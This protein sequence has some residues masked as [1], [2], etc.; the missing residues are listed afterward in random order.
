MQVLDKKN[1]NLIVRISWRLCGEL[2]KEESTGFV[3]I[4]RMCGNNSIFY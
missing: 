2:K 4:V 3:M 1:N